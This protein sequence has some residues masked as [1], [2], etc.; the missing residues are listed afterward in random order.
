M[1]FMLAREQGCERDL[2]KSKIYRNVNDE[3]YHT[4]SGFQWTKNFQ[5]VGEGS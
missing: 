5:R 1:S 2:E 4:L 3:L